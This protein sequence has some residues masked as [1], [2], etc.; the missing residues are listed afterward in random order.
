MGQDIKPG[1]GGRFRRES[2]WELYIILLPSLFLLVLFKYVPMGGLIIAFQDFNIF[3]GVRN[4]EF[5]GLE[6]FRTLFSSHEFYRVLSNTLIINGYKLMFWIPLPVLFAVLL[7]EVRKML[8][9]RLFQTSLYLPHFL[10]WVIVGGIFVNLF[11]FNG[12]LVNE[13]IA[14]LGGKRISF[15]LEPA[16][17]RHIILVSAMWKEVGWGTIVY[18]AAIA[19]IHPQLYE[20]AVMDGASRIRQIWHI[21][22]PGIGGTIVI[23]ALMS[24]GNL[25][26]NSFEQI[27][28]MYNPAV[29]SVADVLETYVYRNGIGQ[30]Q[31]SY[32]TAVGIFS[33]VVGFILV[34][35]VNYLCRKLFHQGMW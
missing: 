4:S 30:M 33:G 16:Y 31:Y 13:I 2:Y 26:S 7:N 19:G 23:M 29:Y 15:M 28:V 11:Q 22:I 1:K 35:S 10:S 34:V 3:Q 25:L 12:G 18:L 24:L 21:T 17:F 6:H 9:R 27:L 14:W 5:V 20:A 32:T 8:L